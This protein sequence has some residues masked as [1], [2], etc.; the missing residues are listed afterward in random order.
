[1]NINEI[2]ETID[3]LVECSKSFHERY[4]RAYGQIIQR[5][6]ED[7]YLMSSDNLR[8]STLTANDFKT[9]DISTGS[10]G[11]IFRARPDINA[12]VVM[13]TEASAAFANRNEV[14][15]PSLDDLAMIVG[16]DVQTC[17]DGKSSSI[18]KAIRQRNA[19]FVKGSGIIA[20]G[21]E[22]DIAIA[23]ARILEKCA[24]IELYADKLGGVKHLTQEQLSKLKMFSSNYFKL[25]KEGQVPFV[26]R[27]EDEFKKRGKLIECGIA[28]SDSDLIQGTWGNIS[29]RLGSNHMLITPSGMNYHSLRMEDIVRL[30]F[31]TMEYDQ[32]RTPSSEYRLH[33]GIYQAYPECNAI[34]HTHSNGCSVFAAAQAGFRIGSPE[35]QDII[36]DLHVSEYASPGTEALTE[37]VMK[38][39]EGSNACIIANHGAIFCSHN[40]DLALAI[41]NAVED[42]ACNLIGFGSTISSLADEDEEEE[43]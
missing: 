39:L 19:C 28:L 29:M 22:M 30:N 34:I 2:N 33:A 1:M 16:P 25:N 15:K 32:Q 10:V 37:N 12:I 40:I 31:D 13:C 11:E 3:K 26:N 18:L 20:V 7:T 8:L 43:E 35:L 17:P 24:E 38:A 42:R 14:M 23:G 36:G 4:F 9:Y 5:L 21:P 41:A 6:D 27:G